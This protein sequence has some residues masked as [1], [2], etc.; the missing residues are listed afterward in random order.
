MREK[1]MAKRN[2]EKKLRG[3]IAKLKRQMALLK[4]ENDI[5]GICRREIPSKKPSVYMFPAKILGPTAKNSFED[6]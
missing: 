2:A 3:K 1:P 6:P 4:V 5:L